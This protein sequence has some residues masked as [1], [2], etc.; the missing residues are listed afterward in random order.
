MKPEAEVVTSRVLV[1]VIVK[2]HLV[3]S[4]TIGLSVVVLLPVVYG[5]V[6]IAGIFYMLQVCMQVNF[7][8]DTK[9]SKVQVVNFVAQ[10]IKINNDSHFVTLFSHFDFSK[11]YIVTD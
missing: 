11:L 1:I 6:D 7:L 4:W 8:L 2:V 10:A 9:F 5:L 3:K